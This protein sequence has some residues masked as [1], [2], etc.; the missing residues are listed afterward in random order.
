M[1]LVF[2]LKSTTLSFSNSEVPKYFHSI[3]DPPDKSANL[4][5]MKQFSGTEVRLIFVENKYL[6]HVQ[7]ADRNMSAYIGITTKQGWYSN[8]NMEV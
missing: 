2:F 5:A 1:E 8:N 7:Y 4:N 3:L 6:L